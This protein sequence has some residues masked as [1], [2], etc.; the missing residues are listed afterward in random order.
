MIAAEL[1][2]SVLTIQ[3]QEPDLELAHEIVD[4]LADRQVADVVLLDLTQLTAFTDY[5][6]VGTVDNIRQARAVADTVERSVRDR[7][8]PRIRPEGSAETGWILLDTELGIVVHLF[9]SQ[10]RMRY[11]LEGLW[12]RA[13]EIVRVQ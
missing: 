2:A 6:I 8:G 7:G 4:W 13:Q 5:F 9:S 10:A 11:D 1:G 3:I 12:N